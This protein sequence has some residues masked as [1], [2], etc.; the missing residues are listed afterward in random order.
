KRQHNKERVQVAGRLDIDTTG[1][2]LITDDGEWNHQLT[3]PNKRCGKVYQV[4]VEKPLHENL[5]DKFE[6]GIWLKQEKTR[7]LPAK[8]EILAQHQAQLTIYEGRY[9]QV[10]RMFAACDNHVVALHRSQIGAIKLDT[11]LAPG[12]YRP[13]TEDELLALN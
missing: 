6:K 9:H 10:K 2:V 11:S 1:L 3:A 13:L 4:E 7:T 5:I 12:E 8:L